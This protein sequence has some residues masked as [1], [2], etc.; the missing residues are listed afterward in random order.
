MHR[1]GSMYGGGAPVREFECKVCHTFVSLDPCFSRVKSRNHCPYGLWSKHVDLWNPGDRLSACKA[2]MQPVGLTLKQT[3]K[4]YGGAG[5]GELMLIHRCLD[6]GKVSINRIA[7]DDN[8][9]TILE[10]FENSWQVTADLVEESGGSSIHLLTRLE[11]KI[12]RNRLY[13]GL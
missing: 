4:K 10:V 11:G 3:Y 2:A 1:A 8:A 5:T 13:G 7:A 12:I 9:G 6:C